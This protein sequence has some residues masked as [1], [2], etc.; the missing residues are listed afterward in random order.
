[1]RIALI[2]GTFLPIVGG[3]EWKVHF[4]AVQY[5]KHGHEVVVFHGKLPRQFDGP[6]PVKTEYQIIPLG[7]RPFSGY[8]RLGIA[9]WLCS[10]Q[11]LKYHRQKPIDIIH[12]HGIDLPTRFGVLVKRKT[13]IPVVATTAG[14]DVVP[15]PEVGW[16]LRTRPYYEKII[17]ENMRSID[18]VGAISIRVRRELEGMGATAQILDIP[19]GVDWDKFQVKSTD[20]IRIKLNLPS[21]AKVIVSIGRNQPQKDFASGLK[22]FALVAPKHPDAH[23]V[24]AGPEVPQLQVLASQTGCGNQIHL[25]GKIPMSEIPLLLWSSDIFFSPSLV[26][27]FAQVVVQAMACGRPCVLSDCAGNEDFNGSS[28]AR[29]GKTGDPTSLAAGLDFMLGDDQRRLQMG[30]EA[31]A[32]S[33]R[34]SWNVIA[35]NYLKVFKGFLAKT[36]KLAAN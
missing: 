30:A 32:A 18:A 33:H 27:G 29:L 8:G 26:E 24:I 5:M 22:A 23:Y 36:Q 13:G 2:S 19:N 11:I 34:F 28:F 35:E 10:A 16:N 3:L 15:M 6:M 1:M 21:S 31:H 14:H 7:W 17:R 12:C 4:L 9:A 25:L 20:Y